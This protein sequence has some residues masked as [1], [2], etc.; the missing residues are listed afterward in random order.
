MNPEG[1]IWAQL[2]ARGQAR[3]PDGFAARVIERAREHQ[4]RTRA[5]RRVLALT[6]AACVAMAVAV[7]SYRTS[8]QERENLV[9]WRQ[10]LAQIDAIER[11][12]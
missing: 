7:H 2:R 12:L 5:R 8:E 10:T 3:L 1:Q 9:R 6:G 4:R 11:A